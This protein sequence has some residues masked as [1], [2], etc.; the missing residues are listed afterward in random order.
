[1]YKPGTILD[2]IVVKFIVVKST[3]PLVHWESAKSKVSVI[4]RVKAVIVL[5]RLFF[6]LEVREFQVFVLFKLACFIK[7]KANLYGKKFSKKTS[8]Q[9][10]FNSSVLCSKKDKTF[11]YKDR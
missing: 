4:G 10:F 3:P 1:M 9:A 6:S 11:I 8:K 2:A 7:T 5:I